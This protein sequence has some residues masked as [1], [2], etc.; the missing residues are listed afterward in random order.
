[1][2]AFVPVL[3]LLAAGPTAAQIR[4]NS[5]APIDFSANAIELQDR[6]NRAVLSGSVVVRDARRTRS[7]TSEK[8]TS[9]PTMPRTK[10]T[11]NAP[12]PARTVSGCSAEPGGGG[13]A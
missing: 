6:A 11:T 1:M 13:G 10:L 12:M 9:E 4:H 5:S 2:R 8:A 7:S 3:L